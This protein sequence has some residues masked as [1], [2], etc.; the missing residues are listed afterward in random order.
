MCPCRSIVSLRSCVFICS[1]LLLASQLDQFCHCIREVCSILATME[2]LIAHI[3]F[4]CFLFIL[5][6][7]I[8]YANDAWYVD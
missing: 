6:K 8:F 2:V 5:Y 3:E 1:V 7:V 4:V